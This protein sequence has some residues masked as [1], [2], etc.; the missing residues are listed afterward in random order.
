MKIDNISNLNTFNAT[1]KKQVNNA[2]TCRSKF[3]TIEI[4]SSKFAE[5]K[6]GVNA[7]SAQ[8]KKVSDNI[9]RPTDP[10]RLEEI[11]EKVQNGTYRIPTEMIADAMLSSKINKE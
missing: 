6:S 7:Y 11:R 9:I 1:A 2:E 3:D 8:I 10:K 4:K 5:K